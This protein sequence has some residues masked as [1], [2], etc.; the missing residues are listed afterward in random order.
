MK[1]KVVKPKKKIVKAKKSVKKKVVKPL[2]K[3]TVKSPKKKVATPAKKKI[4]KKVAAKPKAKVSKNLFDR[5]ELK[6]FK[7]KL[8][9]LR[10]DIMSQIREISEERL[11][12]SQKELSGDISGY[13]L[14]LADLASD[15]YE[16]EFNFSLV[17]GEREI[18]LE[19][20]AALKRVSD[21]KEY[22]TCEM[23]KKPIGKTRLKVIPYSNYCR[24]CKEQVE[25]NSRT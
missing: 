20:E 18:L 16:R 11:M 12:K 15:N 4:V 7:G 23:C 8:S 17:S 14:H 21:G 9:E 6:Y 10:T 24:K 22:G 5:K 1:K 2:K 3:K 13:S 19:I 25:K